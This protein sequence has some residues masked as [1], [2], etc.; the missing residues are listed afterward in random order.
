M[1]GKKKENWAM[2]SKLSDGCERWIFEKVNPNREGNKTYERSLM[3]VIF[4]EK[5]FLT[6]ILLQRQAL[7]NGQALPKIWLTRS[8]SAAIPNTLLIE[9]KLVKE[10]DVP[11]F[12]TFG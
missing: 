12:I 4:Q 11:D 8:F 2:E 10:S 5:T 1:I 7:N 9:K 6:A 3:C